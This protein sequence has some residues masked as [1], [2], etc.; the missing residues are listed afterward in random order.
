MKK[1]RLKRK[2][3]HRLRTRL[4]SKFNLVLFETH[5]LELHRANTEAAEWKA[6]HEEMARGRISVA[7]CPPLMT[8]AT[9]KL[10]F[11]DVKHPRERSELLSMVVHEIQRQAGWTPGG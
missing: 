9:V 5:M 11:Y 3:F 4:A 7:M 10:A 2:L 6:R 1:M 8:T